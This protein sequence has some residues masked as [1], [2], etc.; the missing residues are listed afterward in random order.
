MSDSNREI[1]RILVIDDNCSIHEDIRS[2]FDEVRSAF[3]LSPSDDMDIDFLLSDDDSSEDKGY[4]FQI[5]SAYQGQEGLELLKEALRAD[6]P[7]SMAFVDVRMP[8]GWDGIE[9]I[10]HLWKADPFL[11][12][13]ICTAF[14]DYS[15]SEII[16]KFPDNDGLLVVKK[17][18]D[19]IE[20]LQAAHVLTRKWALHHQL[21]IAHDELKRLNQKLQ[22]T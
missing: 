14:S 11:Q 18:F 8:P 1:Y 9:T 6:N 19:I 10:G 13:V 12:V 17:P 21:N 2:I 3:S 22:H 20:V 4:D 15:W 7:Y 5:D 16:E